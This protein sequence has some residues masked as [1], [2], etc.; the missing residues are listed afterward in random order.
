ML[1]ADFLIEHA[2][3]LLTCAGPAPRRGP[4]Q[5][6]VAGLADAT[7]AARDGRIVFVGPAAEAERAVTP[8]PGATRLDGR[9]HSLV[10]GFVDAHTHVV[11]AGDRRDELRRRLAGATYAEIAAAGGGI[12]STVRA[13]RAASE[14]ALAEQTRG[15]LAE[16]LAAG[17]TTAET[18]SGYGL[19]IESELRML[20]VIAALQ[21]SQPIELAATFMGAHEVPPEYRGRQGEYVDLVVNEM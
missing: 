7:V 1:D 12:L 2:T 14:A 9:G 21:A 6:D 3:T 16:M 10:P 8:A 5:R 11:Y 4:S 19:D 20:R 18:K 15:R 17:T 13:T